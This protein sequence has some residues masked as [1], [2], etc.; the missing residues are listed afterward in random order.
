MVYSVHHAQDKH[1]IS[2]PCILWSL[3][4]QIKGYLKLQSPDKEAERPKKFKGTHYPYSV[5]GPFENHTGGG[6][7]VG[8]SQQ[9]PDPPT[10][11]AAARGVSIE[12]IL[13]TD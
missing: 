11:S 3:S 7:R 2:R 6:R 10:R 12:P 13:F 9:T 8:P 4:E 5:V 1:N